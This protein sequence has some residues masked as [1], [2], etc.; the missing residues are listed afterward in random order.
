MNKKLFFMPLCASMLFLSCKKNE[1]GEGG[2]FS[3]PLTST[4]ILGT[5]KYSG[6]SI[7]E[8]ATSPVVDDF[9]TWPVCEKDNLITLSADGTYSN[10]DVGTTCTTPPEPP[11]TIMG[12]WS[13]NGTA[14]INDDEAATIL[15]FDCKTIVISTN[16]YPKETISLTKQ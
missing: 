15:S 4:T 13:M 16:E 1:D 12:T 11:E 10:V 5:Y 9:A 14:F 8:T 7:Q 2:N 6:Y 3:C